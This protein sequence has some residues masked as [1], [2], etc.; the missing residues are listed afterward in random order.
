MCIVVYCIFTSFYFCFLQFKYLIESNLDFIYYTDLNTNPVSKK[1]MQHTPKKNN[2]SKEGMC[3]EK[4]VVMAAFST[5]VFCTLKQ[6]S[7]YQMDVNV[8]DYCCNAKK[9]F[10]SSFGLVLC[11]YATVFVLKYLYKSKFDILRQHY[12]TF[13]AGNQTSDFEVFLLHIQLQLK[14]KQHVNTLFKLI[15]CIEW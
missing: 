3:L 9:C 13:L 1:P 8:H 4:N 12:T 11:L 10:A 7:F 5:R 2:P 6:Y 15:Y 14:M